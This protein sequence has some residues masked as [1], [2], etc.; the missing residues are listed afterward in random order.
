MT[1]KASDVSSRTDHPLLEPATQEF[2]DGT[3]VCNPEINAFSIGAACAALAAM[4]AKP[5]R[6]PVTRS[7]AIEAPVGPKGFVGLHLIRP[8]GI[9]NRLPVIMLFHGKGWALGDA[10]TRDRLARELAVG[11]RAAVVI[12]EFSRT[13]ESRFSVALE[14]GYAATR[15]RRAPVLE[16]APADCSAERCQVRRKRK[17]DRTR[18]AG[19]GDSD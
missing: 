17:P 9:G 19:S 6:K 4:Q 8:S 15:Y 13:P 11:I 12:V 3:A 1:E 14:E 18:K 2:V 16:Y 5:T 10:S 7:E